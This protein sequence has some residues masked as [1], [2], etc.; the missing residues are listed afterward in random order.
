[1]SPGVRQLDLTNA[2]L[3]T[4]LENSGGMYPGFRAPKTGDAPPG[5]AVVRFADLVTVHRSGRVNVYCLSAAAEAAAAFRAGLTAIALF[6]WD[7]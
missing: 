7:S 2:V 3:R 1:M 5:A 4:A 6:F